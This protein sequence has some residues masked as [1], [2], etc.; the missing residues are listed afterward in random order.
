MQ[1]QKLQKR[2]PEI[3]EKLVEVG[4]GCSRPASRE[5]PENGDGAVIRKRPV[6]PAWGA[7]RIQTKLARVQ[8]AGKAS[9]I[10]LAQ[11]PL[12]FIFSKLFCSLRNFTL[13]YLG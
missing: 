10:C 11:L 5:I 8:A 12:I 1:E 4:G 2:Q 9:S 3:L 7:R 6:E 13:L